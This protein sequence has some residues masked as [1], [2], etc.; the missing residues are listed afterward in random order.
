MRNR[1]SALIYFLLALSIITTLWI[2]CSAIVLGAILEAAIAEEE[3][4][5][6]PNPA[7]EFLE[8]I[9]SASPALAKFLLYLALLGAFPGPLIALTLWIMT[10]YVIMTSVD[11]KDAMHN[12]KDGF[13]FSLITVS[14]FTCNTAFELESMV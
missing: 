11:E 14:A 12:L 3:W 4:M 8:S 5:Y 13:S 6:K 1:Q 9:Y 2:F 10:I 7:I